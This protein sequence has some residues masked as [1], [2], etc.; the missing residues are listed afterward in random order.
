[1]RYNFKNTDTGEIKEFTILMDELQP[2]FT[3]DEGTWK[4]DIASEH[5]DK[6]VIIPDHM[7]ATDRTRFFRDKRAKNPSNRKRFF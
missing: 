7:K 3:D 4:R 5:K 1:M 6:A 2:E